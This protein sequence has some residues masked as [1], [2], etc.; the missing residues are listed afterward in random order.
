METE[1]HHLLLKMGVAGACALAF[2]AAYGPAK[3][4]SPPSLE[5]ATTLMVPVVDQ[6]D[7]SVEED[8]RP[9]EEPEALMGEEPKKEMMPPPPAESESQS[10][11]G[12]NIEDEMIDEIGP[13]AE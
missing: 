8:L 4:V 10:G 5:A 12:A 7:L 2:V 13:G 1:M 3:A 9:D 6:E 11:S